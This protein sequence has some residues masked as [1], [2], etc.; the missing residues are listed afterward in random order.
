MKHRSL[1][2]FLLVAA[3][4]A[5]RPPSPVNAL[6]KAGKLSASGRLVRLDPRFDRLVPPGTEL[7]KVAGG[8]SWVEGPVW[9]RDGNSL[10][11]SDIPGNAIIRWKED[12]GT[13]LY[14]KPSGYTGKAPFAGK[15][16]GANGLAFDAAGRLVLAEH[17]DRRIARLE[18]DGSKTTLADRYL[19][20]R[21]NS[22][23][24]LVFK[25]NG[26]LY[27]TDPPFGLPGTFDD[28]NKEL[29]FS[30]VFRLSRGGEL[31]L[32]TRE[33]RAPNGIAF[34]PDEKTLYISSADPN[35]PVW[36]AYD[37]N[38]DGT[39]DNGRVFFDATRW[40]RTNKGLPDGMK[41]DRKGN[42]FAAG[43]GGIYVFLPDGTHLGT[44][45]MGTATGN[46]AWGDDGF[47]LYIAAE[48]SIYRIRLKTKGL[49]F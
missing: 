38:P 33:I 29:D 46:C 23:N 26:D 24:D 11:F 30:G 4:T 19:G 16:P 34:S 39:I 35:R 12:L 20:K 21:L 5:A 31:T 18:K 27:F 47:T 1:L 8:F 37:V 42:L 49:G 7:E 48:T 13:T 28:P 25:S 17:G 15:E 32:L 45:E 41:V 2:F 9:N 44:I 22:P 10:L 40:T 6:G 3:T 14:L 43:P 36:L